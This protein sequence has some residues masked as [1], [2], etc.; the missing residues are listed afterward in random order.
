MPQS[1]SPFSVAPPESIWLL[2]LLDDRGAALLRRL[3]VEQD[4]QVVVA[5]F[6]HR[7]GRG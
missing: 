3:R 4:E 1:A 2:D 6:C 5:E 7:D